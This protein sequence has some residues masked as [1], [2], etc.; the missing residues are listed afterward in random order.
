MPALG[1][2]F[3]VIKASLAPLKKGLALARVAV[4]KAMKAISSMV[5]KMAATVWRWTKRIVLGLAAISAASVKL[6]MDAEESDNL[7]EVSM[8]N[9]ADATRKWSKELSRTLGLNQYEIRKQVGV[10]NVMLKSMGIGADDARDMAQ[11]MT[12]LTHDMA[13]FYNLRPDEAFQKIQ[14]GITGMS[15]PLKR[16]GILIGE[17]T[18]KTW[19]QNKGMVEQGKNLTELQKIYARY[20]A[21]MEQTSDSQG[22]L[23]R[24]MGSAT[25]QMRILWAQ[26][27]ETG[28]EL[29][30]I[31][32]PR[33]TK[34]LNIMNKW[35]AKNKEAI[36]NWADKVYHIFW[37]LANYMR[38]D[39]RTAIGYALY[40]V[41]TIF[42]A[43]VKSLKL[44]FMAGLKEMNNAWVEW[45]AKIAE[46][47]PFIGKGWAS[48]VRER[49]TPT[50]GVMRKVVDLYAAAFK[51][52]S[53][54]MPPELKDIF[55]KYREGA[56]AG[57]AVAGGAAGGMGMPGGIT[58]P[59]KPPGQKLGF[60]GLKEL[61]KQM[62]IGLGA[63]KD[64]T[65]Q[66]I[67][68]Y[69]RQTAEESAETN[70]ILNGADLNT[71]VG[72]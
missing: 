51:A 9:M 53:A 58:M 7:F 43:F 65:M 66:D 25:N 63:K 44:L 69:Q 15:M 26:T 14:S 35:L 72:A 47:V 57:A 56:A 71:A 19:A 60:V 49:L 61:W 40:S 2:A 59:T 38:T 10:L 68:K 1:T 64:K 33:F 70:R 18:I 42:S 39:W 6:A 28:V 41:T 5:K 11:G 17:N 37:D 30:N 27:K 36:V 20:G 45:N 32:L 55:G 34:T 54:K 4:S 52:I 48:A 50:S 67:L 23:E 12:L 24:T 29:G 31:F 3:V 8:G 22:D 21:L 16:I 13:S 46:K 62:A